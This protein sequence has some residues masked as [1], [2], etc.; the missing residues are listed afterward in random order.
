VSVAETWPEIPREFLTVVMEHAVATPPE[1][2][3]STYDIANSA[4]GL[5]RDWRLGP[6]ALAE[7]TLALLTA[8]SYLCVTA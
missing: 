2:W 5:T 3:P 6:T 7:T 8:S 4:A 1:S